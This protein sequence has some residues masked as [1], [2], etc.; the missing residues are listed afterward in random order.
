MAIQTTVGAQTN[1]AFQSS[2]LTDNF[3]QYMKD[4]ENR[5]FSSGPVYDSKEGGNPTYGYGHKLT[6]TEK[7]EGKIKIG[8]FEIP[9]E[10]INEENSEKMLV[11]D[12]KKAN[13]ILLKTYGEKYI[14]LD[15]RRKQML[16]D[17]QYNMGSGGVELFKKFREALFTGDEK[18]M[19]KEYERGYYPSDL[20]RKNKTNFKKLKDR[21]A[22]FFS[23]FFIGE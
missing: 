23:E 1:D 22:R 8:D 6:N 17:F 11:Q 5:N 12:L 10:N 20:D 9:L 13:D 21:N 19:K 4:V 18:T 7:L 2:V 3:V 16:I 14:N 15:S